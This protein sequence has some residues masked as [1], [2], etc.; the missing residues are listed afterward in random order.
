MQI[1]SNS[2]IIDNKVLVQGQ[3]VCQIKVIKVQ[4]RTHRQLVM[5]NNNYSNKKVTITNVYLFID[6]KIKAMNATSNQFYINGANNK[7]IM[8]L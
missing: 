6:L 5:L 1:N 4:L 7:R 3:E 2:R 8:I